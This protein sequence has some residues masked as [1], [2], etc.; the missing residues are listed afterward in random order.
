MVLWLF[1]YGTGTWAEQLTVA[2]QA[3]ADVVLSDGHTY[4]IA[5]VDP[6]LLNCHTGRPDQ[7]SCVYSAPQGNF[8]GDDNG[9]VVPWQIA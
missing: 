4:L 1:D 9:L 2:Y 8:V 6:T 5:A 3:Q 7:V